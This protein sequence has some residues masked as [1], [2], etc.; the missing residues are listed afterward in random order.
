MA[1]LLIPGEEP[2]V[3]R[4]EDHFSFAPEEVDQHLRIKASMFTSLALKVDWED[5]IHGRY[6]YGDDMA[7]ICDH[8]VN[9][10]ATV[11]VHHYRPDVKQDIHGN[12][13]I[14]DSIE[15]GNFLE[16]EDPDAEFLAGVLD[17]ELRSI[18]ATR[19]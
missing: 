14:V 2:Q 1:W 7:M 6:L 15:A 17:T 19:Q 8:P 16:D 13:L 9:E 11:I 4:P 12:I 10:L 18:I 5:Q 3:V